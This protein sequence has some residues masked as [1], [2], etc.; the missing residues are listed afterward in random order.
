QSA[1]EQAAERAAAEQAAAAQAAADA[2]AAAARGDQTDTQTTN[3]NQEPPDVGDQPDSS[4]S[5]TTPNDTEASSGGSNVPAIASL[6]AGGVGVAMA[7]S[8][9]VMALNENSRVSGLECADTATCDSAPGANPTKMDSY[10]LLSDI[11]TGLA[12]VGVGLGLVFLLTAD[13]S[14]RDPSQARLDIMPFASP[15]AAGLAAQGSF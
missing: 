10:A 4:A 3:E 12:I 13:H 11:G 9:G 15:T 7:V 1:A 6:I 5:T 8:F 2:Q 14:E